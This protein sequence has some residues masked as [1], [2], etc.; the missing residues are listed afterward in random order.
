MEK[1]VGERKSWRDN[2]LAGTGRV[3]R[4]RKASKKTWIK[5]RKRYREGPLGRCT[6]REFRRDER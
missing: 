3:K 4:Y 5:R 6:R 2:H 1:K